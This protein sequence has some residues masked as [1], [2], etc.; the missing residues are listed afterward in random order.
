MGLSHNHKHQMKIYTKLQVLRLI[1][2]IVLCML[3]AQFVSV[4]TELSAWKFKVE[5]PNG[6][7]NWGAS[8]LTDYSWSGYALPLLCLLIGS[9]AVIQEAD[10]YDRIDT[11]AVLTFGICVG[12]TVPSRLVG[13][14]LSYSQS[15]WRPLL[16]D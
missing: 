14:V 9:Y 4:W 15:A 6:T 10:F 12:R 8:L 2:T 13:T 11:L 7:H 5:H 3:S 16:I 1:G